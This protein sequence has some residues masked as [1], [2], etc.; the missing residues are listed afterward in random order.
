M[1]ATITKY[2]PVPV[3]S[4]ST[5]YR[6]LSVVALFASTMIS[7]PAVAAQTAK[8]GKAANA[9]PS[10][11]RWENKIKEFESIQAKM[12]PPKD[13]VLLVGGSNARR[14]TDVD[15]YFPKHDVIN[16]GFGGARLTD[17]L[18]FADR[19]V[20]PVK[21]TTILINAGGNDLKS[22]KSPKEIGDTARALIAKVRTTLPETSIYFFGLPIVRRASVAADSRAAILAMNGQLAELAGTEKNVQFIDLVPAFLDEHGK[23]R[24]DLFVADGTHFSAKGYAIITELLSGKF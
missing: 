2:F 6:R 20:L 22:G 19:I 21:P 7:T 18:H 3:V 12:P 17:I 11:A 14:W 10:P 16:R 1:N 5:H 8:S 4:R 13:A 9:T 23:F 15:E 24:P